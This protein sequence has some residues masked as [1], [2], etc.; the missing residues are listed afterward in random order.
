MFLCLVIG[1]V[2]GLLF[3]LLLAALVPEYCLTNLY[4]SR[5]GPYSIAYSGSP[6]IESGAKQLA[7]GYG[8]TRGAIFGFV[9]G[10]VMLFNSTY[11]DSKL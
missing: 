5:T 2:S 9:M 6:I 7:V 8:M 3:G 11:R 4:D 10:I 1:I